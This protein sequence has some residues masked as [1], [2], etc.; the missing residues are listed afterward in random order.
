[1]D[2]MANEKMSLE[3]VNKKG[4]SVL[5]SSSGGLMISGAVHLHVPAVLTEVKSEDSIMKANS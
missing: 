1:M 3:S 4:V 2:V 5:L